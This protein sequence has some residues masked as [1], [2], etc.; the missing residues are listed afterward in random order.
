MKIL[1]SIFS[2]L[3]LFPNITAA[4]MSATLTV[5]DQQFLSE[6]YKLE[7]GFYS[8]SP[9]VILFKAAIVDL[10]TLEFQFPLEDKIINHL[11][12]KEHQLELML[13]A[14]NQ[15]FRISSGLSIK[16]NKINFHFETENIEGKT[17]LNIIITDKRGI[18]HAQFSFQIEVSYRIALSGNGS[19]VH[20]A[21]PDKRIQ[22][23]EATLFFKTTRDY[24]AGSFHPLDSTIVFPIMNG[25]QLELTFAMNL[26]SIKGGLNSHDFVIKT[27]WIEKDIAL[28]KS[29]SIDK[30]ELYILPK[31]TNKF[32]TILSFSPFLENARIK[33]SA[34]VATPSKS[35]LLGQTDVQHTYNLKVVLINK[36]TYEEK[37]GIIIFQFLK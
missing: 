27:E 9:D 8:Y 17:E 31:G 7:S 24:F 15:L 3:L 20:Q 25:E 2:L 29:T 18:I 28:K 23:S 13:N 14:P 37:S 11:N 22:F 16:K 34:I 6:S 32:E 12:Y 33:D 10:A 30:R 5:Q 19:N 26:D 4:Q 1:Q 35:L 36:L 21:P